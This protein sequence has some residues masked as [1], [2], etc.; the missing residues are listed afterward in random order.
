MDVET[1]NTFAF[2]S[3]CKWQDSGGEEE[4]MQMKGYNILGKD[5][6]DGGDDKENRGDAKEYICVVCQN[7]TRT[8]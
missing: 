1:K 3:E 4:V 6:E 5:A 8:T 2:F 7:H